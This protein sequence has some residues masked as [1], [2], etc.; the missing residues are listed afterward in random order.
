MPIAATI[1]TA[2]LVNSG[3]LLL[4]RTTGRG[5][6]VAEQA[7]SPFNRQLLI[8]ALTGQVGTMSK[9]CGYPDQE[10]CR[11]LADQFKLTG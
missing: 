2:T 7:L 6:T 10:L 11:H 9:M 8:N 4:Y 3:M 1:P 5:S